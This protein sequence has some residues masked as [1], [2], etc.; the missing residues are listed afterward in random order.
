MPIA[1]LISPQALEQRKAQPGLVILDC[2]FAL[3]DP[4]Y[5]QRSYAEGHIAGASF[6]DLE[7]D[8][9]G[10]VI[11]GVTG[12]HPL[13]EPGAL[14]ERLR[15]WGIN[16]DSDI[17]L[18]DDGPGAY[19]ARAWWLL[20]WLGKRE[21]VY[22][23]DG[24][25]KAWHAEGLPLSLD[26]PA[27]GRGMFSGSPDEALLLDAQALQQCLGQP[28]MTLLDARALPRF[29]GE[30]EPIDPVAGHIPGAQ[31]AA[32]TDNLGSDGR[33]LPAD[34]LKKRFAEK[35]GDRSPTELVAYCGSGVTAC[36][37][38]FALCLAGYP[39]G[40]LYAGSWSEWINDPQRGVAKGE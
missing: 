30:V 21:G 39:L 23:L 4:D 33:F 9:S 5:G 24:G 26:P 25:L 32:F 7:R 6:A 3:D 13:P 31:C 29:K 12:R 37:N 40:R 10:P 38:L 2:R 22:L 18:Y 15:A 16:N 19:S 35:L 36:H 1:Q 14:I 27:G 11:K 8:L 34:R 17:V 28:D 20:A